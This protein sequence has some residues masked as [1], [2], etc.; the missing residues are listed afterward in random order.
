MSE[1]EQVILDRRLLDVKIGKVVFSNGKNYR[2]DNIV[3]FTEVLGVDLETKRPK[4]LNIDDL[5]PLPADET[6]SSQLSLDDSE[7]SDEYWQI[8]L[9]RFSLIKPIIENSTKSDVEAIAKA[10]GNHFTTVYNWLKSYRTQKSILSLVPQKRGWREAKS[11]L[12]LQTEIILKK[13]LEDFY[14]TAQKPS[15]SKVI[16]LINTNCAKLGIDPPHPNTVRNRINSISPYKRLKAHGEKN[17]VRDK[18]SPA[19]KS[20]PGADAPLVYVQIDHTPLD[21]IIVDDEHRLPIG[22]A[23]LTLAIDVYSRVIVGYY[24]SLDA[25]SA[26]SVGMC[27]TCSILPKNKL[28]LDLDVNATWDV[29]GVMNTIHTDNGSDFRVDYLSRTCLKYNINW[30]YR[31]I[32]GANFGGH[33]ER[34]LG[35]INR[36]LHTIPGATFSNI[37]Q[38]GSYDSDG[39]SVMTFHELERYIVTWITKVYHHSKHSAL[40]MSPL[41]K[42]EEGIWGTSKS[43]GTGLRPKIADSQTLIIDFLPEFSRTVQRYGIEIDNLF[44]YSDVLRRWIGAEDPENP[45]KKRKF[46]C[47]RDPRDVSS[48]WF[49]DPETKMYF[50]IPTSKQ[51][52]PPISIWEYSQVQKLISDTGK[53]GSDQNVI[54]E[55]IIELREQVDS[56]KRKTKKQRRANQRQHQHQKTSV[57]NT[58][59]NS[60]KPSQEKT[61]GQIESFW[62]EP[63]NGFSDV[64]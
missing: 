30:E 59:L 36:E 1:R 60:S 63:V 41:Q 21:I 3:S 46:T 61:E 56:S 17:K 51:E 24:L 34:L 45:K 16:T 4:L 22:R 12:D 10:S 32:G 38:R 47:K 20:F 54:Y 42:W 31:P 25:P 28:L 58:D 50:H 43:P 15:I 48:I 6:N 55:A 9:E 62:D 37:Q 49:Y 44:Y 27:V 57:K 35:T 26:I 8:A 40:G 7:I 23:Y 14:L 53:N 13:A 18:Y 2:I 19:S 5:K 52:I 39:K 29:W 64:R 11:R 33:I